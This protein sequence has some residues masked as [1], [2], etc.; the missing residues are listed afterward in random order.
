MNRVRNCPTITME[1]AVLQLQ[2]LTTAPDGGSLPQ[3]ELQAF[4]RHKRL[5]RL[6][7]LTSF[8]SCP[9][10]GGSSMQAEVQAFLCHGSLGMAG[11]CILANKQGKDTTFPTTKSAY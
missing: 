10:K 9:G 2:L 5:A 7:T 6:S 8:E 4:L 11:I 1:A 3:A